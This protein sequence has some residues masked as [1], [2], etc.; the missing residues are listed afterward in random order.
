MAEEIN[1]AI[2]F[3]DTLLNEIMERSLH[4]HI[5]SSHTLTNS[6]TIALTTKQVAK[7]VLFPPF[8]IEPIL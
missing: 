4:W 1:R 5:G 2:A 3:L 7:R 6:Y 8:L